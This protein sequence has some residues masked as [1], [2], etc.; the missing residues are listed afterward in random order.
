MSVS[1]LLVG[2]FTLGERATAD[3]ARGDI[4]KS[5]WQHRLGALQRLVLALL[6]HAQHQRVVGR[7]QVRAHN[8]AQL[9]DE[10]WIRRQLETVGAMR[11]E[12]EDL[13]P[14]SA[15][16]VRVLQCVLPSAG[17]VY[18][19]LMISSAT[20]SSSTVRRNPGATRR[21]APQCDGA[22][23]I[24]QRC[25]TAVPQSPGMLASFT[26]DVVL[27]AGR[28]CSNWTSVRVKQS[29]QRY[30]TLKKIE[31]PSVFELD[32]YR[33][34][35]PELSHLAYED[36]LENYRAD[37]ISK[38]HLSSH[39]ALRGHLL[40]FA[41]KEGSILEIGPFHA[42]SITG[43]NV[44]YMDVLSTEELIAAVQKAGHETS[45]VP[46]IHY[47]AP[48][49]GFDMVDRK[50]SAVFSGHCI[51]H[52]PDLIRHFQGVS[53]VLEDDGRYYIACPDRRYCFDHYL[54][55]QLWLIFLLLIMSSAQCIPRGAFLLKD[56]I[57]PT[58]M[59]P[60]IGQGTTKQ[61]IAKTIGI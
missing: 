42:P 44:R 24:P 61:R 21:K 15:A 18:G 20:R 58:M 5:H 22:R 32:F 54:P 50:F 56:C 6:V 9:L 47:V 1:I 8:V 16:I 48:K 27:V 55:E 40:D 51:E 39:G 17:L 52:Q 33:Q 19:I 57:D 23:P 37:G 2:C 14:V 31:L 25:A 7:V 4:A 41:K 30:E 43:V 60:G 29:E 49:G 36:A 35:Q 3:C 59:L 10:Q 38:G 28:W 34:Q 13:L 46:E 26:A 45:N 12:V 53:N 11:L